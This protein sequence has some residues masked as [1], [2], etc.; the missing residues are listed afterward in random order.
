[1]DKFII[2][3]GFLIPIIAVFYKKDEEGVKALSYKSCFAA[4]SI[5][6]LLGVLFV[7]VFEGINKLEDFILLRTTGV[8]G[9][10]IP[11][12]YGI[13]MSGFILLLKHIFQ[14]IRSLNN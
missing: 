3:F 2:L 8:S 12:G 5:L 7:I 11:F 4:G 10:S 9:K 13:L 1:M 14:K 6:I